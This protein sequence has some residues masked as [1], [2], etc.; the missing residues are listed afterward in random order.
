M[1]DLVKINPTT[2]ILMGLLLVVGIIIGAILNTSPQV[3]NCQNANLTSTS[4][5]SF[6]M[7][8]N[9]IQP[10]TKCSIVLWG[11]QVVENVIIHFNV[12]KS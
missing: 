9:D 4:N 5:S 11:G 3:N 7:R 10:Y 1:V 8:I 2:F 12:S 6:T